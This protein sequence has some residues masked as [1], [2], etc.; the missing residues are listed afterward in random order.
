MPK[1]PVEFDDKSTK[2]VLDSILTPIMIES[3]PTWDAGD[4]IHP[5]SPGELIDFGKG[6]RGEM[7]VGENTGRTEEVFTI[8]LGAF[9]FDKNLDRVRDGVSTLGYSPYIKEINREIIM[10]CPIIGRHL[11][12][13]EA[14]ALIITLNSEDFDSVSIKGKAGLFD[15]ASG[16]FYYEEDAKASL[17]RLEELGYNAEIE[18][19]KV[20]VTLKRLRI[21]SYYDIEDA[22][23]DMNALVE[24]GFTPIIVNKEQ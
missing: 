15:V 2:V 10:Y 14:E 24:K 1:T 20:E 7:E 6:D 13:K 9:I 17:K 16:L 4:E 23:R 22:K 12:K 3:E 11:N 5:V 19:R 8:Q 21:G 18:G